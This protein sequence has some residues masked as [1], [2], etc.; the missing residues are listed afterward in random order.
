MKP[1]GKKE[2]WQEIN[3]ALQIGCALYRGEV[4]EMHV[5]QADAC[6]DKKLL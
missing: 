3:L 4:A 2:T 1:L 6:V 5:E